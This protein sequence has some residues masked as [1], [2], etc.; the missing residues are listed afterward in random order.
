[1]IRDKVFLNGSLIEDTFDWYAQDKEGNVWYFGE[2]PKEYQNGKMTSTKES[3]E[4]GAD[5]AKPGII[6]QADP[7]VGRPTAR[8]TTRARPRTRPRCSAWTSRPWY[9]TGPSTIS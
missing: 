7:K 5:G 2:D 6:M 8:S 1:M 9:P 3:W 4:A